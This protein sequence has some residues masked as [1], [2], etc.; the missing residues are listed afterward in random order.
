M[1]IMT[2]STLLIL[3]DTIL[4][5][6]TCLPKNKN[7]WDETCCFQGGLFSIYSCHKNVL[8]L[9]WR[10]NEIDMCNHMRTLEIKLVSFVVVK[11]SP[12]CFGE[13]H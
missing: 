1:F 11:Q 8:T 13:R 4:L 5:V 6:F 7:S 2:S 10:R 9:P 3:I 12:K